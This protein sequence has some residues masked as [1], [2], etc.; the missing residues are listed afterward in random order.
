MRIVLDNEKD[1]I[2]K[3]NKLIR[4]GIRK[5]K[6]KTYTPVPVKGFHDKDKGK[7]KYFALIGSISGFLFAVF[8]T[9]YASLEWN[10]ILGGKPPISILA[11]IVIYY[12]LIILF[13]GVF[14]FVG[15]LLLTKLPKVKRIIEIEEMENNFIIEVK[16]E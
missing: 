12:A 2:E 16:E 4:K 6:I 13:G 14:S 8:L 11:F 5:N 15:F 7:I 3:Y 10:E 9:A 1:F